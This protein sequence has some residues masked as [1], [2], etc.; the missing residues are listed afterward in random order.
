MKQEFNICDVAPLKHVNIF[1][2]Q[3]QFYS[4][5]TADPLIKRIPQSLHN[6]II[7]SIYGCTV[8]FLDLGHFL[9][10]LSFT[11]LAGLLGQG[12]SPSQGHY[13]HTQDSIK[14]E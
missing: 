10:S 12:I 13:L 5:S 9:V 4:L 2:Q 7:L 3:K 11:Q 14:T 8:L 1:M 6:C